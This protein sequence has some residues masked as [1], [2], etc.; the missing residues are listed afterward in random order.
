MQALINCSWVP[1]TSPFNGSINTSFKV[2]FLRRKIWVGIWT[3]H[4]FLKMFCEWCR[5]ESPSTRS[6]RKLNPHIRLV[7][8]VSS[9]R[10]GFPNG[11]MSMKGSK[12]FMDVLWPLHFRMSKI[13]TNPPHETASKATIS[14]SRPGPRRKLQGLEKWQSRH[15]TTP[16]MSSWTHPKKSL[17]KRR[18]SP[19]RKFFKF[20]AKLIRWNL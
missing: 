12:S 8:N 11:K 19:R 1:L 15:K 9:R 17:H 20:L 10:N 3:K 7:G 5:V 18:S 13:P 6:P 16:M 4:V 2:F 14:F